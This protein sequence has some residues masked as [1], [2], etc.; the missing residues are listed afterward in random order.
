[1]SRL[2]LVPLILIVSGCMSSGPVPMGENLFTLSKTSAACGFRDAGGVKADLSKEM[3]A[4]CAEKNL[5]PE[6]VSIEAL[7]GVI[8]RRCASATLEFRCVVSQVGSTYVASGRKPYRDM[9]RAATHAANQ[10][11]FGNDPSEPV[12]HLLGIS[13]VPTRYEQLKELKS[14]LDSGIITQEEFE[15]EKKSVLAR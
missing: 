1:M 5:F 9:N 6:L 12:R 15:A 7:D 14:L 4:F 3:T 2:F 10:G 11:H 8:G 13:S